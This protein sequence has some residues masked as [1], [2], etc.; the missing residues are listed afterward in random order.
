MAI[1]LPDPHLKHVKMTPGERLLAARLLT[2]LENDYHCWFEPLIGHKQLRPDFVVLHPGR[3][4]LILEVKDWTLATIHHVDTKSVEIF[5]PQG[6]KHV[7]NPLEQ[8]RSY[9]TEIVSLLE[10]DPFLVEQDNPRYKGRLIFPWG[11]GVVLPNITRAQL[12]SSHIDRA[13]AADKVICADEMTAHVRNEAFQQRLWAMFHYNF[14]SV[15]TMARI[16]R[17]RFHLFPEV[18]ISQQGLFDAQSATISNAACDEMGVA[19]TI[20]DI[21]KVMD[22]EQEK[23]ARNLGDGHRMIHGV[24]GS[25]KTL[26]LAQRAATLSRAAMPLPILVLCYN[27]TLAQRLRELLQSRGAG[28]NVHIWHFHGWC[29]QMCSLYQLDLIVDANLQTYEMQVLAVMRGVES[30]R[31]PR[32]QYSAILIDEGHDFDAQWYQLIVQMLDPATDS[33]LLVYDDVQSIYKRKKPKSWASVGINVPG[34]RSKIFKVNYRNT[35]EAIDF[36][37]R[38]VANYLDSSKPSEAIPLVRPEQSL[39]H[40]LPPVIKEF[41]Y[42]EEELRYIASAFLSLAET[43]QALSTMAVLCRTNHQVE[44]TRK[45]LKKNGLDAVALISGSATPKKDAVRVLTMHSSKGLEF[46]HVAIPDL[47]AMPMKGSDEADEARVL[48]VA[49]TR[50]SESLLM[51]YHSRSVFTEQLAR[52]E[53]QLN[54]S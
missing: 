22:I 45:S 47:G 44:S 4:V 18:R 2:K 15:L 19:Q 1:L 30:G 36:A 9:A 25:G 16:D 8:A 29:A 39:R 10:R 50:A 7:I 21:V 31:V 52:N 40:G 49:M 41:P 42:H 12:E 33:L 11:F 35:A 5:T 13:I 38:F 28:D 24:A 48:Y 34:G 26:I 43:G 53:N 37:Y 23:F 54:M 14:G 51:T 6:I 27:K 17:I 3:G 32:A 20:P 46:N